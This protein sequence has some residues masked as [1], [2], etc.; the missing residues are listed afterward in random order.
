MKPVSR[1][2]FFFTRRREGGFLIRMMGYNNQTGFVAVSS[3]YLCLYLEVEVNGAM[4]IH[5][6]V[7]SSGTM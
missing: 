7:C 4:L 5:R 6:F 1:F 3:V 2:S